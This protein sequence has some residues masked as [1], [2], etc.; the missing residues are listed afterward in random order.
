[1]RNIKICIFAF[2]FIFA[3]F[4]MFINIKLFDSHKQTLKYHHNNHHNNYHNNYHNNHHNCGVLDVPLTNAVN[5][6][7]NRLHRKCNR[8]SVKGF[9]YKHNVRGAPTIQGS[10]ILDHPQKQQSLVDQYMHL[11]NRT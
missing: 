4:V 9:R 10:N 8:F 3:I 1:M 11:I 2:V 7:L 6:V 5:Y